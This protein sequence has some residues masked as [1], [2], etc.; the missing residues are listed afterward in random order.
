MEKKLRCNQCG[1]E[2]V[3]TDGIYKEDFLEARKEWGYFS[4][5]DFTLHEFLLCESCYDKL[6]SGFR[7]PVKVSDKKEI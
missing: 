3:K 7:I 4:Q 1:K 6:V 5:K 2:F